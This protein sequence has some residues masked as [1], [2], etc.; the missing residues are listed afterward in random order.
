[1]SDIAVPWKTITRGQP[2][3]IRFADDR[4]PKLDEIHRIV[5]YPDRR[6]QKIDT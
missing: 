5:G 6:I 4:A 3:A 2:K 1:M